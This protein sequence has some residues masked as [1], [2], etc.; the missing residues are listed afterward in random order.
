MTT[1]TIK[2]QEL[3]ARAMKTARSITKLTAGLESDDSVGVELPVADDMTE[4]AE[5]IQAARGLDCDCGSPA[6]EMVSSPRDGGTDIESAIRA[7]LDDDMVET[8]SCLEHAEAHVGYSLCA[9]GERAGYQVNLLNKGER[10]VARYDTRLWDRM[11]DGSFLLCGSCSVEVDAESVT[12]WNDARPA[13]DQAQAVDTL[14][15]R[16]GVAV[17]AGFSPDEALDLLSNTVQ[18]RELRNFVA[19]WRPEFLSLV[20]MASASTVSDRAVVTLLTAD[21]SAS[22]GALDDLEHLSRLERAQKPE[23]MGQLLI[24]PVPMEGAAD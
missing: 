7:L 23:P 4:I 19:T 12:P 9:C 13:P 5:R 22:M 8:P 24:L 18:V 21:R 16:V 20:P 1:Y 3:A 14:L 15:A 6:L 17:E 11:A 2:R 10:R